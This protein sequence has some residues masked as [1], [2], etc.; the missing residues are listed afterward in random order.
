M[1]K[2]DRQGVRTPADLER[3][4]D[5]GLLSE[6]SK[7]NSEINNQINQLNQ[8]M[9]MFM[10][11]TNG[12]MEQMSSDI[13]DLEQA[14]SE[15]IHGGGEPSGGESWIDLGIVDDVGAA[16]D[17]LL[18]EGRYRLWSDDP[19]C[20]SVEVQRVGDY[21]R[22]TYWSTEEG[23]AAVYFRTAFFNG[24]EWDW[25]EDTCHVTQDWL[26]QYALKTHKHRQAM[27][28]DFATWINTFREGQYHIHVQAE[29][30]SYVVDQFVFNNKPVSTIHVCQRYF[31]VTEPW[32]I[33][34]RHGTTNGNYVLV[35]WDEWTVNDCKENATMFVT[36][37]TVSLAT[38][39][40][41]ADKTFSE[42]E[43]A[44][45]AGKDV[46]VKLISNES[47]IIYLQMTSHLPGS[48]IDFSGYYN[49]TPLVLQIFADE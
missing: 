48:E 15:L 37:E 49:G 46:K 22:Q 29:T 40:I 8:S 11:S 3:K 5:F 2:Q 6:Q 9:S 10:A 39:T 34:T 26:N 19:F 38:E 35:N 41:N 4:Y 27:N 25:L 23:G 18:E 13:D 7:A 24:E 1:S 31:E 28:A 20:Y 36:V 44:I 32:K 43:A 12:S 47:Y 33:Y 30:K 45:L 42:I 14:V 17:G 16:L 21:V